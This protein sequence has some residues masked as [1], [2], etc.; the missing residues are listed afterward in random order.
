MRIGVGSKGSNS[1]L[2]LVVSSTGFARLVVEVTF[3]S[4]SKGFV[5]DIAGLAFI[6]VVLPSIVIVSSVLR[7]DASEDVFGN[8]C[9]FDHC[10]LFS[11]IKSKIKNLSIKAFIAFMSGSMDETKASL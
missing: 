9:T 3:A 8:T 7:S 11:D 6:S 1:V 2:P 4:L 10:C 5:V